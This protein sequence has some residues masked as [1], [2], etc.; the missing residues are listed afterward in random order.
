[1]ITDEEALESFLEVSRIEGI[2][3]ALETAHAFSLAK[4]VARDLGKKRDLVISLSGRGDKDVV[5]VLRVLGG[6][7]HESHT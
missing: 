2:I 6:E 3:P 4:Q 5:E 7:K 1:M